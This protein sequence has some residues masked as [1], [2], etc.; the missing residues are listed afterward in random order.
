M[1]SC[2]SPPLCTVADVS[3]CVR[4]EWSRESGPASYI[5]G[6]NAAILQPHWNSA[7]ARA[8]RG[9]R[10]PQRAPHRVLPRSAAPHSSRCQPLP[11]CALTSPTRGPR[12]YPAAHWASTPGHFPSQADLWRGHWA[13]G[14]EDLG[15]RTMMAPGAILLKALWAWDWDRPLC[16]EPGVTP[17][18]HTRCRNKLPER[19]SRVCE[20]W[21]GARALGPF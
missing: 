19:L 5:K 4:L 7:A 12:S 8:P 20:H 21:S 6:C 1:C 11:F 16:P 2:R 15:A 10:F 9:G 18:T 3:G 17:F 14:R 13:G